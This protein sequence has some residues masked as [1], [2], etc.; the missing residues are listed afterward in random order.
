MLLATRLGVPPSR[1]AVLR[2]ARLADALTE[3]I[4]HH[5][6]VV[7]SAP[8]GYGKTTL[9]AEWARESRYLVVWVSLD[10]REDD[11]VNFLRYLLAGWERVAPDLKNSSLSLLLHGIAPNLDAVL[12]A[13]LNVTADRPDHTVFVLDDY[14][15]VG[16]P[17]IHA[18]LTFLLDHLPPTL[19]FVLAGRGDPP[20]QLAR[21]RAR[22]ELLEIGAADLQFLVEETGELL[23]G[24]LGLAL[25][26]DDVV[27]LHER[28][29]GWVAG[30][31]LVAF[32]LSRRRPYEVMGRLVEAGGNRFIAD[33]LS[34]DV[35]A[36]LSESTC[37]FL[38]ETSI[39]NRLCGPL[40]EA[41]TARPDG[42]E[43]LET[44][45]RQ[46]VF[47]VGLDDRREW[48]RYHRLFGDFL[49]GELRRRQPSD[50]ATLHRRA[51]RWYLAH[52][53]PEPAF[54]HAVE[55]DDVALV[56]RIVED[57]VNA[58]LL[59]GEVRVVQGWLA[60][61][62]E[63][64]FARHPDLDLARV[65][66][67]YFTG[68]VAGAVRCLED[69]ERRLAPA[70]REDVRE[71][72]ARVTAI[73]CYLACFQNDLARA[74]AF[75]A[76]ALRD[77]PPDDR[78]FRPGVFAALGDTYRQNGRWREAR[79]HYLKTLDFTRAPGIRVQS[80]H[81]F[82]ALADLSL[83][84]G[85]LREA[86][87]YWKKALAV[88]EDPAG[89]GTYSL[90]VVGWVDI[91]LGEI[92]YEWNELAEAREHLA[93]GLERAELGGD[94]RSLIAGY[95]LA[96]RVKL[97]EDDIAAAS[98]HLERARPLVE[99]A[100]FPEWASRFDRSQ[101]DLWLA[102]G[103]L[104]TA[105]N[106]ADDA[107]CDRSLESR[108]ERELTLLGIA[109]VLIERGDAPSV[110]RA[111]VLLTDLLHRSETE[112]RGSI[113]V[114]ALALLALAQWRRADLPG[115]LTAIERALRL[116]EPEGYARTF[117]DLGMPITRLLRE[118]RSREVM[119]GYADKLLAALDPQQPSTGS[120]PIIRGR[121]LAEPLSEREQ[122]V[123]RLIA[124]GLTNREIADTL[125][126]SPETVKKHSASIYGKLGVANRTEAA[127]RGRQLN[128]LD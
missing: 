41:V 4:L 8:A 47:L 59:G 19:H 66:S 34:Q 53:L 116:A 121:G 110:E 62:P 105:T 119:P 79:E 70:E 96:G 3:A 123:L 1:N 122:E 49:Q 23:N 50:I 29:E 107:L 13:F 77:L 15:L 39:L 55:G 25:T 11:L 61:L 10:E 48:F 6:L 16:D 78:G 9:L 33:Y 27:R 127:A 82:G 94:V 86:A 40:C 80:V 24:M 109:R 101:I 97:A 45:E 91:R 85:C 102:R 115:A 35:L 2:R 111:R 36:H 65:G 95:L 17:A 51:A 63:A 104:Q 26:D 32:T 21:Y 60:S 30:L 74:E 68:D 108:P 88:V 5:K 118:A 14:H 28:L 57:Y 76:Q 124:A 44:L 90:P 56:A 112:G 43:M 99:Q 126:I 22:R 42:Q 71:R 12:S 93:R 38:L 7:L 81:V 73:R 54:R 83:R 125:V 58:K 69:V 113:V 106:W 114:E 20:L 31:H 117:V 52:D 87:T 64:W 120:T 75:A 128:L 100:P 84:Q 103:E 72:R 98:E 37:R 18:A 67:L 92:L 46:G 89:W